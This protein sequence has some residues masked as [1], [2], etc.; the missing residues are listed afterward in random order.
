MATTVNLCL[1]TREVLETD[2][3][4]K[5]LVDTDADGPLLVPWLSIVKNE[6]LAK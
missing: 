6:L 1:E 4:N 3:I 5:Q 2:N